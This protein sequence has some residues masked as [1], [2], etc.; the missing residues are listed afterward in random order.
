MNPC[1]VYIL[2]NYISAPTKSPS[3]R[4][5]MVYKI[6]KKIQAIKSILKKL[7]WARLAGLADWISD[8]NYRLCTI[9]N[10]TVQ[11]GGRQRDV[12]VDF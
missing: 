9:V 7:G 3:Q 2:K 5:F 11:S 4:D 1:T 10:V 8:Q 12:R 6:K